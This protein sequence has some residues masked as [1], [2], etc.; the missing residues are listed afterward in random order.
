M[1]CCVSPT[2]YSETIQS[3]A[4]ASRVRSVQLGQAKAN[5]DVDDAGPTDALE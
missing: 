3:L 5:I 2:N 1:F 4:F